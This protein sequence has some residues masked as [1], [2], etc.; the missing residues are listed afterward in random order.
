MTALALLSAG[1]LGACAGR[2]IADWLLDRPR[3]EKQ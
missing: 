1:I 3:K 2:L